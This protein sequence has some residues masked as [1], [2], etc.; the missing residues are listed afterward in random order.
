M[1]TLS[2]SES[3]ELHLILSGAAENRVLATVRRWPHW[4]RVALERDPVDTERFLTV[5][6][7]A[8]RAHEATVREILKRSFGMTFPEAGGSCDMP[9]EPAPT[10]RHRRG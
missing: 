2:I 10:G 6:L 7:V 5:T 4:Q 3:G 8:D 9:P 1:T